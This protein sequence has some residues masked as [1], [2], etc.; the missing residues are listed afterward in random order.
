MSEKTYK[1]LF[2]QVKAFVFDIDGVLT[3]GRVIVMADGNMIRS[4]NTRDGF[5]LSHA[6]KQGYKIGV[7][8]GGHSE[9]AKK[10]LN[11]L[12]VQDVYIGTEDKVKTMH[13]FI[14]KN[15]LELNQVLYM[16]DDIPDLEVMKLCGVPCCPANAATEIKNLSVYISDKVGGDACVRDVIEQVMRVQGKWKFD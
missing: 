4:M 12:G 8:S 3:D 2:N 5:A 7:I 1:Q 6:V 9:P 10:R 13:D 14:K 16:G 15:S 11:L